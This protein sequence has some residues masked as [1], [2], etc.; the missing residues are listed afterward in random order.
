MAGFDFGSGSEPPV[1]MAGFGRASNRYF[2][3]VS[4]LMPSLRAIHRLDKPLPTNV[5]IE[6]CKF[7][8]S[9]FKSRPGCPNTQ[10]FPQSGFSFDL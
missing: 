6:C 10:C 7:T 5:K 1:E 4:R 9:S 3:T 2:P 8:L